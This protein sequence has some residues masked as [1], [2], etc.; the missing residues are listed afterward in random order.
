MTRRGDILICD[1]CGEEIP[2]T[3]H[4]HTWVGPIPQPGEEPQHF[5]LDTTYPQCRIA[6]GIE[7][8]PGGFFDRFVNGLLDGLKSTG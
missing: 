3:R 4:R 8:P 1:H 7:G 5:H 2:Q 6:G